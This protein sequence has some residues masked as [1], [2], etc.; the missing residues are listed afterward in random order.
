[1][2]QPATFS[3]LSELKNNNNKEWFD[4][5]RKRYKAARENM[6]Q[7]ADRLID[8]I[9]EFD[10]G[11][12]GI[13]PK[14][15]LFRI[16]RDIRFSKN[17]D[18]YKSNFGANMTRGGKKS[19]YSGYYFNLE[20]GNCFVAGGSYQPMPPELKQIRESLEIKAA[21]F[22]EITSNSTFKSYFGELKGES[23]KTAPKGYPKDHPDIDLIRRKGFFVVGHLSDEDVMGDQIIDKALKMYEA[24][25]P[26]NNFLNDAISP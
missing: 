13:E 3:F 23:L 9:I 18:P 6:I 15:T 21:E 25:L 4:E 14:K 20:P 8:G 12:M 17:K 16:N 26:L 24:M 11:L 19:P 5:N 1:M 10:P 7:L 2:I 22:R